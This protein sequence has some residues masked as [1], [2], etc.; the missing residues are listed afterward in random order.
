M[1]IRLATLKDGNVEARHSSVVTRKPETNRMI[2]QVTAAIGALQ[3]ETASYPQNVQI[4]TKL[5]GISFM[6]SDIEGCASLAQT[7]FAIMG[8]QHAIRLG[9]YCLAGMGLLADV[10][11]SFI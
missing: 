8:A 5:M 1:T 9:L 4:W 3:S 7:N 10:S 11:F 6:A 2:E